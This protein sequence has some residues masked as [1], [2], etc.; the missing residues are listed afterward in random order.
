V[1]LLS[2]FVVPTWRI[3]KPRLSDLVRL[4][5]AVKSGVAAA[6]HVIGILVIAI[7]HKAMPLVK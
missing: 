7:V 4:I 1:Q 6:G 3:I 2:F 5:V